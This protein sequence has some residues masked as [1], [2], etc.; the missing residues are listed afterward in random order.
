MIKISG[1]R[2]YDNKRA[3]VIRKGEDLGVIRR[4]NRPIT[5]SIHATSSVIAPKAVGVK[6]I[7]MP[8]ADK[9]AYPCGGVSAGLLPKLTT[10]DLVTVS[11]CIP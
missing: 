7:P 5:K 2:C 8:R 9:A 1:T 11:Y 4:C 10:L 6:A 3:S